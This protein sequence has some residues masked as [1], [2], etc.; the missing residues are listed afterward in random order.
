MMDIIRTTLPHGGKQKETL[1]KWR[2]EYAR[3]YELVFESGDFVTRV[4]SDEA[5]VAW[6]ECIANALANSI[7]ELPKSWA[8]IIESDGTYRCVLWDDEHVRRDELVDKTELPE[9]L[10]LYNKG[11][12]LFSTTQLPVEV[13]NLIVIETL[14][15]NTDEFELKEYRG[16][17]LVRL[18][19]PVIIGSVGI[20]I[21]AWVFWP[22]PPPP[23]P[24]EVRDPWYSY[25]GA[26]QDA[27]L[28]GDAISELGILCAK[29]STTP[30]PTD[31]PMGTISPGSIS[32][33]LPDLGIDRT[34]ISH[35]ADDNKLSLSFDGS[36]PFLGVSLPVSS[37]WSEHQMNFKK[38]DDSVADFFSRLS[39]IANV[40]AS[41]EPVQLNGVWITRNASLSIQTNP[42]L[43]NE[44]GKNL[45]GLPMKIESANFSYGKGGDCSL[46][47]AVI[48]FGG[49]AQ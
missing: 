2:S 29:F 8:C 37:Y 1:K 44:I 31:I 17:P 10:I 49:S 20:A 36:L 22:K 26:W 42:W 46:S 33:I 28:A 4:A 48:Q 45:S 16:S 12:S 11:S 3:K 24:P 6:G 39:H 34:V 19:K 15:L 21:V 13:S 5:E 23:P 9:W 14:D 30:I 43:M 35:W 41:F 7:A 47:N 18:A 38:L 40:K 25:R 32:V 27:Q